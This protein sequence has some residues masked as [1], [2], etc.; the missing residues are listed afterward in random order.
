MVNAARFALGLL[1]AVAIPAA[2]QDRPDDVAAQ[3]APLPAEM[4]PEPAGFI[5]EPVPIARAVAYMDRH[6]GNGD[7]TNGFYADFWSMIPGAG[8]IS[9]GPG[10]RSWYV[11]DQIFVDA[12]AAIS[13]NGYKAGQ[14]RFE[15]PKLMR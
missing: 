14:A 11:K 8:W 5:A 6:F 2:A 15:L 1:C 7:L 10:Y 12:S 9:G 13:W 3:H 4:A